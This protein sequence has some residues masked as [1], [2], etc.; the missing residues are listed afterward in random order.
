VLGRAKRTSQYHSEATL[1]LTT[2]YEGGSRGGASLSEEAHCGGLLYRGPWVMKGSLWRRACLHGGPVGQPGVGS[3][4]GDVE[5]W[6]K[7]ALEV[8][9]LSLWELCE[10]DLEGGL[11]TLEDR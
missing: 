6:L 5:R 7:G 10:G 11:G 2:E 8:E 1:L 4:T 3:S 9:C